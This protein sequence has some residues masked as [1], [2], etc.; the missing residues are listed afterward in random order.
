MFARERVD[1]GP[2]ASLRA[3][4]PR[5]EECQ[6]AWG[7]TAVA[8]ILHFYVMLIRDRFWVTCLAMFL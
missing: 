6:C 3:R 7:M 2:A 4:T 8:K 1:A 5:L